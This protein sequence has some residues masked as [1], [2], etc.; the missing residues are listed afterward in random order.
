MRRPLALHALFAAAIAWVIA[1]GVA[2]ANGRFPASGQLVVDP[3]DPAHLAVETTY[4]VIHT[5]DAGKSWHYVCEDALHY[6]GVL[7]PPIGLLSGGTLI[8]GVFD[9]LV[10]STPDTCSFSLAASGLENRFVVDVAAQKDDPT[11]AIAVS[12]N[13]LGGNVFDTRLWQ[14]TDAAGSWSQA[15]APLPND[16]LAL[17]SDVAPADAN[18]VYLSGFEILSSTSYQGSIARSSDR[19][20]TWEIVPIPGSDNASGPYIAAIDPGD[21]LTLY[22]RLDGDAGKLLVSHDGGNTWKTVLSAKGKLSAFALSPDGKTVLAGGDTD[23]LLRAS[24]SDFAFTQLND[25][26]ARCLTWAGDVVYAC[27]REA[28]ADFPF[29]VGVSHDQG[30]TFQPLYH[31]SCLDGPDPKCAASTDVASKCAG[32]WAI[33]RQTIQADS[34][35]TTSSSSAGGGAPQPQPGSGCCA[36]A[37]SS[38]S[39]GALGIGAIGLAALS[40]ALRRRGRLEKKSADFGSIP[41]K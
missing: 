39:S 24:T 21:P 12:S 41:S 30:A 35:P 27:G 26:N 31:L 19:G 5:R 6:G 23:G 4:G 9:G 20:A 36:V 11:K 2:L 34:C 38:G 16:F 29:T 28:Q 40:I 7:D 8:A 17:T 10:V 32:P 3:G 37:A 33:V 13:G 15:G 14:T 18:R 1:P 25:L 22:V